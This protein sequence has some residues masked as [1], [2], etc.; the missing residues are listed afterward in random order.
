LNEFNSEQWKA[1]I[2][3]N[4]GHHKTV[5]N[6]FDLQFYQRGFHRQL[7]ELEIVTLN[8]ITINYVF[9]CTVLNFIPQEGMSQ[10]CC[11][12]SS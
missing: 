12:G 9:H 6:N 11:Y 5:A 7:N 3:L 10:L 2:K 1:K 8:F 4:L